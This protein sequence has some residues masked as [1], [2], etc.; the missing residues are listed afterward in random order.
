MMRSAAHEGRFGAAF[1][2]LGIERAWTRTRGDP[3]VLIGIV[4]Q[5]VQRDHP[6]LGTNIRRDHSS[7]GSAAGSD[8]IAGTHAAGV[9]AGRSDEIENFSGVA[10]GAR[11]LPVRYATRPG[12]QALDLAHAI[13][14][15]VEMGAC[16]VNIS[17]A[18]DISTP[19]ALRAIEY[20]AAKN[21][22]V[23][24]TAAASSQRRI[25]E[26][27][28]PN[29]VCV[30]PLDEALEPLLDQDAY[31]RAHLAAPG[32]ARVPHWRGTGHSL[33]TNAGLGSPYV[34]GC[35]ALLKTL[36]PRW[37]YREL[38]EHLLAS[39]TPREALSGRCLTAATL[40]VANAVLGPLELV[41]KGVEMRWSSLN[42]VE[43]RWTLR[44]RSASCANVVALYRSHGDDHWRDLGQARARDLRMT[45]P[46]ST[47]RRSSGTL[48]VASRDSNFHADDVALSIV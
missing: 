26:S 15:A 28:A 35:A 29:L 1:E 41:E 39:G 19:A 27:D 22:L 46:A 6:L 8:E 42:D 32:F 7:H 40:N 4:D 33:A 43:L 23:I 9:A 17:H 20:A 44:Y 37:G 25:V 48:R 10:P 30:L 16:I 3:D 34:S 11:I 18:G 45:I 13:E 2:W 47:L 24:A 12:P 5:G 14:Y 36:N 21:A 31:G 38:K